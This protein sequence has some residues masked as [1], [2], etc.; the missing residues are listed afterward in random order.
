MADTDFLGGTGNNTGEPTLPSTNN[1]PP[2]NTNQGAKPPDVPMMPVP[3]PAT[4]ATVSHHAGLGRMVQTLFGGND[5]SYQVDPNTGQTV[6]VDTPQKPGQLFRS[7][8]GGALLG[9]AASEQSGTKNFVGG[10]GVG[11]AAVIKDKEAKDREAKENARKDFEQNI[12]V[13]QLGME[14]QRTATQIDLMK[15]QIAMHN[16]QTLREVQN[17]QFEDFD[18]HEKTA[19]IGNSQLKPFIDAGISKVFDNI[20]ETDVPELLK[21]NPDATHLFWQPTGTTITQGPD[22][23]PQHILTMSAI[24]IRPGT[25]VKVTDQNI[26][27]W[28]E[29]GLDK[30][31]GSAL[32]DHLVK[33]K[34]LDASHFMTFTQQEK[35]L[36]NDKFERDKRSLELQKEQS[37][38]K[39]TDAQ[40][41]HL[42]A[43]TAKYYSDM[44]DKKEAE[45][46]WKLFTGSGGDLSKMSPDQIK[47]LKPITDLLIKAADE[48]RKEFGDQLR[49]NP[50]YGNSE[51][52]KQQYK[53]IELYHNALNKIL[54]LQNS[55]SGNKPS[56][57]TSA[58]PSLTDS[59]RNYIKSALLD[60]KGRPIFPND[61]QKIGQIIWGD[62]RI[63]PD[64][65]LAITKNQNAIV[66]WKAVQE[67]SKR[68]GINPDIGAKQLESAGLKVEK[69]TDETIVSS[70]ETSTNP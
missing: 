16:A 19:A 70:D 45:E 4:I 43:E 67:F 62:D 52:G 9:M 2:Q 5:R 13:K 38:L 36:N 47:K 21:K 57:Q 3:D 40:I 18:H 34:T 20:P 24:D 39:L 10:V 8:L 33:D 22:G 31:Y 68:A 49:N 1:I 26:K 15:A 42:H 14:Q 11:G 44:K 41:S 51:Q 28:K 6:P 50:E 25:E 69:S 30:V 58:I 12:K 27:N 23:K 48:Q 35:S 56:S 17:A 37:S 53:N 46:A 29:A 66:P 64:Q 59:G 55:I 61:P 60:T 32:W 7:I 54:G 65:K 63:T